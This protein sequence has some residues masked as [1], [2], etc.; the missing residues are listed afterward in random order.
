MLKT[1]STQW[2]FDM[3]TLI[4]IALKLLSSIYC[5]HSWHLLV[6]VLSKLMCSFV[7]RFYCAHWQFDLFCHLALC[8]RLFH[9]EEAV[10]GEL[11]NNMGLPG[12]FMFQQ[13]SSFGQMFLWADVAASNYCRPWQS[14]RER[15]RKKEVQ[16]EG[17]SKRETEKKEVET[18]RGREQRRNW[19]RG[20]E[21]KRNWER[22]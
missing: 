22:R 14:L 12:V 5:W 15:L 10:V 17:E 1:Y 2:V 3:C 13:L 8:L 16:T 18:D 20:R 7:L 4:D 9:W 21:Q 6:P 19:D 11:D